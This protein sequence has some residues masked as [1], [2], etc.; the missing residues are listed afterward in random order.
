MKC[1]VVVLYL[2]DL[3]KWIKTYVKTT[4][5]SKNVNWKIFT[6]RNVESGGN[7]EFI[8]TSRDEIKQRIKGIGFEPIDFS[9]RKICDY[10][11]TYGKIF[12]EYLEGY[13]YWGVGDLDL[14]YGDVDKFV[15]EEK[16]K[17]CDIYTPRHFITGHGSFFKNCEK[18]NNYFMKIPN[19]HSIM[20]NPRYVNIDERRLTKLVRRNR[21]EIQVSTNNDIQS[22]GVFDKDPFKYVWKDGTIK[23]LKSGKELFY[24]H[25]LNTK[26]SKK[27]NWSFLDEDVFYLSKKGISYKEI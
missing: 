23:N 10:K 24:V 20:K 5:F 18:V 2:G 15:N 14:F 17:D 11:L 16:F 6:N 7:V 1:C 3:P 21:K 27:A 22:D 12:R 4:S 9:N 13:D 19:I 26:K 8:R 25:F